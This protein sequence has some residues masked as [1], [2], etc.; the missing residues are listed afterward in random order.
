MLIGKYFQKRT[1]SALSYDR[2]YKSFY[3]IAVTKV[4][5][6]GN[7]E[8][9]LLSEIKVGDRILV[10]NQEIIPVDAILINGENIDNSFITGES[11]TISKNP[12][13]KIFAGG[14]QI[15]SIL[16]LEVIKTVNQS[17]LTQ[18]W[19]KEAF[20]KE[21]LGLDTLVNKISKYFTFIILGITLL[22]EFIGIK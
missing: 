4:D 1:Y 17:Y 9:I 6:G 20:R 13:D 22:A 12:G 3:P 2:D 21:E 11:A 8:N 10:R 7:Q 19:N 18:L 5:F 14:K 16:E 15:G